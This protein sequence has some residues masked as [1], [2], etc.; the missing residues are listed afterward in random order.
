MGA[1]EA[2]LGATTAFGVVGQFGAVGEGHGVGE[3]FNPGERALDAAWGIEVEQVGYDRSHAFV[4]PTG[5]D[6]AP[7]DMARTKV[8]AGGGEQ[9]I[10]VGMPRPAEFED[11]SVDEAEWDD[12]ATEALASWATLDVDMGP[13]I[14]Q[15]VVVEVAQAGTGGVE[16]ERPRHGFGLAGDRAVGGSGELSAEG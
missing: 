13:G 14:G 8:N 7:G 10:G 11:G 4:V 9:G 5:A 15:V 1:G 3:V 6:A 2:A 16:F 12:C